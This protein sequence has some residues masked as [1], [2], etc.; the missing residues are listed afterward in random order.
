VGTNKEENQES[1]EAKCTLGREMPAGGI[2]VEPKFALLDKSA[3]KPVH[4]TLNGNRETLPQ[5]PNEAA[6]RPRDSL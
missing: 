6:A 5:R 4:H 2:F 3:E 1:S